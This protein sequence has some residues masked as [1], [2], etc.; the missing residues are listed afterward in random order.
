MD[1]LKRS[2]SLKII[3]L[4]AGVGLVVFATLSAITSVSMENSMNQQM[5]KSVTQS[6]TLIFRAI[7]RPMV[8]GDDE[9]TT[10]EFAAIGQ[11]FPDSFIYMTNFK[12]NI[13][14]STDTAAIRQDFNDVKD[15]DVL[16][17]VMADSLAQEIEETGRVSL[18]DQTYLFNVKSIPNEKACYHCHFNSEPILG[19]MLVLKNVTPIVD[20][21]NQ[22][23]MITVA[24]SV[25]GLIAMVGSII[26]FMRQSVIKRV[27]HVAAG[28]KEFAAGNL[29]VHFEVSG[30]D[31][32]GSLTA[33]MRDMKETLSKIIGDAMVSISGIAAICDELSSVASGLADGSDQQVGPLAEITN[34]IKDIS[35]NI[36][37]NSRDA[38]EALDTVAK[39]NSQAEQSS[40]A[41]IE[42]LSS[43]RTIAERIVI[44]EEIARQTNLLA[45]NAAIEAARAGE[46]GKGF[47]VVASEVR[48]LAERSG[49]AVGEIIEISKQTIVDSDKARD[50]LGGLMEEVKTTT[51]IV[52][53]M[54]DNSVEQKERIANVQGAMKQFD[55]VVQSNVAASEELAAT[56]VELSGKAQNLE[57]SMSFFQLEDSGTRHASDAQPYA[58]PGGDET[59]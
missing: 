24:V 38:E 56:S 44:V 48:K 52:E 23:T 1:F 8:V 4:V 51:G 22:Q 26:L 49:Q 30:Q 36:S 9:G 29:G 42:A 5:V 40:E 50:Q 14:Y 18:G 45:L 27:E 19:S 58:L 31:E 28:S 43:V 15:N 59:R 35:E 3:G 12:G 21:I 46:A 2:L 34:A 54:A 32:V 7:E 37:E 39:A 33:D 55:V 57:G 53:K 47:A 16:Q 13:T 20:D 6:V 25:I 17:R 41:I 10:E 11:E